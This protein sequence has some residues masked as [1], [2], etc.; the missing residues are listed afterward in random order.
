MEIVNLK[1]VRFSPAGI[2]G[3]LCSNR[4]INVTISEIIRAE[5]ERSQ[6]ETFKMEETRERYAPMAAIRHILFMPRRFLRSKWA[7]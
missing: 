2:I 5:K 3:L 6:E 1:S 7:I 4:I